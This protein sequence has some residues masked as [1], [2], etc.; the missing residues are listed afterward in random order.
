MLLEIR[1]LEIGEL[2]RLFL[3]CYTFAEGTPH[4]GKTCSSDRSVINSYHE[5][6]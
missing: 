6:P 3:A 2:T 4:N 1:E 5:Q